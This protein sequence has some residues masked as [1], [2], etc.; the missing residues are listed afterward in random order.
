MGAARDEAV[1]VVGLSL[2]S[3]A[4]L[5]LVGEVL[6]RLGDAGLAHLPLVVGGIIPP[7]DA[8][9]LRQAGVVAVFTP[10]DHDLTAVLD[11]VV[12]I[13]DKAADRAA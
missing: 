9:A 8:R 2:L 5:P 1:H 4:H 3:G 11:K 6:G 13:A 10:K 7:E 12:A